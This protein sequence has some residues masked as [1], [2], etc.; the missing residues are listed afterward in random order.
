[1]LKNN[2]GFTLIELLAT[3]ALL[4]ILMS[5]AVSSVFKVLDN[6]KKDSYIEDAKKFVSQVDYNIRANKNGLVRPEL[7]NCIVV[8]LDFI[9]DSDFQN[10]PG[11]G[12]YLF[13][14]SYIVLKNVNNVDK[15]YV[16]LVENLDKANSYRGILMSDVDS[17]KGGKG[18][19][20]VVGIKSTSLFVVND[21]NKSKVTSSL[22]GL[23]S[24]SSIEKIYS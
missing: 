17:L 11:G 9:E 20:K 23:V 8:R 21:S 4:A 13:D 10:P 15:F 14:K 3:L 1:M 18:R 22:S 2:K 12:E 5:V 19:G 16:R 7:N 24:C 6:S